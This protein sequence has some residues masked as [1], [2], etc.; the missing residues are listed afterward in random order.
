MCCVFPHILS[1][2]GNGSETAQTGP[3]KSL[4]DVNEESNENTNNY[5]KKVHTIELL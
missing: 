1:H 3:W 4:M 2:V 5:D